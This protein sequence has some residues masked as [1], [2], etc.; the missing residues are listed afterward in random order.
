MN[1]EVQKPNFAA[2]THEKKRKTKCNWHSFSK[3]LLHF[4]RK[5]TESTI[6]LQ[7]QNRK[8]VKPT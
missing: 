8:Q 2:P 4:E 1:H 7:I 6:K 5:K 3:I